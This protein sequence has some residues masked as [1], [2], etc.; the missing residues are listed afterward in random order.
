MADSAISAFTAVTT[1]G[2]SDVLPIVSGGAT[3]KVTVA[4]LHLQHYALA[5][6]TTSQSIAT[7]TDTAITFPTEVYDTDALFTAAGSTFTVPAGFDGLWLVVFHVVWSGNGVGQREAYVQP[8]GNT[9]YFDSV[10]DAAAAASTTHQVVV[11]VFNDV[12][13]DTIEGRVSQTSGGALNVIEARM[14]VAWLGSV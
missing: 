5:R 9:D 10:I 4:D 14:L 6:R 11:G 7:A 1:P 2:L 8:T 13:T 12:A 3:K